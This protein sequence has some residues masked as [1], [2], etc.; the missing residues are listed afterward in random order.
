MQNLLIR[1]N[2]GIEFGASATLYPQSGMGMIVT[3]S[4]KNHLHSLTA[5]HC[6]SA[7]HWCI[8]CQCLSAA[9]HWCIRCQCLGLTQFQSLSAGH[10]HIRFRSRSAGHCH[11]RCQCPGLTQLP[12][13][14][15]KCVASFRE[16]SCDMM[17]FNWEPMLCCAFNSC[18]PMQRVISWG[19]EGFCFPWLLL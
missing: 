14:L 17:K 1:F 2:V 11:I 3:L 18:E 6:L 5:G 9:G 19:R 8:H 7:G 13:D 16:S 15:Q 4:V 10:C 12:A